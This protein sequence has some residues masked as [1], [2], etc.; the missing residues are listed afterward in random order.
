MAQLDK[1][2]KIK[3]YDSDI[4]NQLRQPDRNITVSVPVR[5]DDGSQQIFEGYRVQYSKKLGPYKGG[6]RYHADTD[7]NEVK[8]LAFWMTLKCSVAGVPMGGGKGGITVDPA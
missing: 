2:A 4:I 7:I 3:K 1:V 6:I 5:M 8:A